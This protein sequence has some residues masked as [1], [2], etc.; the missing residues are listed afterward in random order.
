MNNI[1]R[2]AIESK[3]LIQ[4]NYKDELRVVEPYT[5][6]F[7]DKDNDL[8][9][10]YQIAGESSSHDDLGWRF[11]SVNKIDDLK[12]LNVMFLPTKMG[13]KSNDSSTMTTI[14]ITA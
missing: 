13:Y 7:S 8:L 12:V 4:F 2:E 5:Y 1:I 14:Y 6:G 10:G 11:F 3:K 9:R